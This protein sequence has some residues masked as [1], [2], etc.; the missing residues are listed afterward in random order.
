MGEKNRTYLEAMPPVAARPDA[1]GQAIRG[2]AV[3]AFHCVCLLATME[4]RPVAGD[5]RGRPAAAGLF[6]RAVS[7]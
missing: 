7:S 6:V 5:R 2:G 1:S 3:P 4:R